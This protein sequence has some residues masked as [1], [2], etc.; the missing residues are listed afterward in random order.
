[1]GPSS[2]SRNGTRRRTA[3]FFLEHGKPLVYDNG[4]RGLR[5]KSFA[6][7][8]IDLSTGKWSVDDCLVY[9]EGSI[10]LANIVSR[11]SWQ[12]DLPRPFGVFFREDRPSYD[13]LVQRQIDDVTARRGEGDL[14]ALL[15]AGNTWEI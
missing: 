6:L 14:A 13:E 2:N 11:M 3:R 15:N 8:S 1:M 4:Q 12:K 9:D 10:E 5:L 7:E